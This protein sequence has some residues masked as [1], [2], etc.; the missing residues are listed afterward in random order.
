MLLLLQ[1]VASEMCLLLDHDGVIVII[2][3][4]WLMEFII[5]SNITL[6]SEPKKTQGK[7]VGNLINN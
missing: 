3:V 6:N 5:S 7:F 4:I 1:N 2:L